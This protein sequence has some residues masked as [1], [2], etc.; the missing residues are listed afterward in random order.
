MKEFMLVFR[1]SMQNEEVF[2]KQSPEQMQTE[3]AKWNTW[4]AGIAQQ[5]KLIGGQPLYPQCASEFQWS[6]RAADSSSGK[7]RN[8]GSEHV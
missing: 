4:M 8:A 3:L 1:S 5:G 6:G 2:A 7:T